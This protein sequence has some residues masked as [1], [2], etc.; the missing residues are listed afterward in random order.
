MSTTRHDNNFD[1][2]RL[3]A[4]LLVLLSHQFA[5][6]GRAEP[7]LLYGTL[8][9]WGVI[10]FFAISGYLVTESWQRDPHVLRFLGKR[11]LRVWPG[12]FVATAIAALVLGPAVSTLTTDAYFAHPQTWRYFSTLKLAAV[13]FDLPGVFT[14]NPFPKTV[15][16]SLWSIPLEVKCYIALMALG[17][18]GVIARRAWL[19]GLLAI[20]CAGAA[21]R[22]QAALTIHAQLVLSFFVGAAIQVHRAA[23]EAH[24]PAILLA[25]AVAAAA[26]A[27]SSYKSWVLVAALPAAAIAAGSASTPVLKAFGRFGDLSYG[28][29]I[30]AFMVQQTIVH[31]TGNAWSLWAQLLAALPVTLGLAWL[32]WHGVERPALRYKR[33][34]K[35][36]DARVEPALAGL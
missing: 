12:L 25:C 24:R 18:I 35:R 13:K 32:S 1:F 9:G 16:G 36:R 22:Y 8:G 27:A 30:Y 29:Y 19:I 31:A 5:L 10:I 28:T 3:F 21:L 2:L 33:Y 6:T 4:A 11:L 14:D 26:F 17:C 7:Q 20:G 34:S 23:W 15:N